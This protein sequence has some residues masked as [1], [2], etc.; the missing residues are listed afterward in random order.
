MAEGPAQTV[1]TGAGCG[2]KSSGADTRCASGPSGRPLAARKALWR[3]CRGRT[4]AMRNAR[5]DRPQS[6]NDTV[7]GGIAARLNKP[8][9]YRGAEAAKAVWLALPDTRLLMTERPSSGAAGGGR[10]PAL[11]IWLKARKNLGTPRTVYVPCTFGAGV[12][13]SAEFC[14]GPGPGMALEQNSFLPPTTT[15][16][17]TGMTVIRRDHGELNITTNCI[18]RSG[19]DVTSKNYPTKPHKADSKNSL[20]CEEL[21]NY[22]LCYV[23]DSWHRRW[24]EAPT[25]PGRSPSP[26]GPRGTKWRSQPRPVRLRPEPSLL[27]A[28]G[29][30]RACGRGAVRREDPAPDSSAKMA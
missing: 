21:Y 17:G 1:P 16:R 8:K 27:C 12:P 30:G 20:R 5:E 23:P 29:R 14:D 4:A 3:F 22:A 26:G 11:R 25:Q 10:M 6:K 7:P 15:G 9:A 18:T 24:F 2:P 28:D 13:E 19:Q